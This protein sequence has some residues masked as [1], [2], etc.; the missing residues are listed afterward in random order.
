[1]IKGEVLA[2]LEALLHRVR[3]RAA[4]PRAPRGA[5]AAPA[6]GPAHSRAQGEAVLADAAPPAAERAA[7]RDL[8]VEVEIV[9][10]RETTPPNG[11]EAAP[12]SDGFDSRERL[13][14]AQPVAPEPALPTEARVEPVEPP[15]V[16]MTESSPPIDVTEIEVVAEEEEEP[17]VSSRRPVVPEPEE[18]LEQL[19]FGGEEPPPPLHTPPP[20]SG[21]LPS[22]PAEFDPDV[23]GVR[24]ATPIAPR[25]AGEPA[26]A[27]VPRELVAEVVRP[28]LADADAVGEVI[29]QAQTFAPPTFVALLD[30][31]LSL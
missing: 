27:G 16:V 1:M 12:D 20:E 4:E 17:P 25:R 28:E 18:R 26:Q 19:A 24:H 6:A 14:A 21:R 3:A 5:A 30:A 29:A 7:E 31:S 10:T 11:V 23:T 15:A 22:A 9:A 8:A 13:V 2:K